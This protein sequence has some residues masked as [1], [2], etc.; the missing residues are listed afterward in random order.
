MPATPR[1]TT[2]SPSG[3]ASRRASWCWCPAARRKSPAACARTRRWR[4][5]ARRWPSCGAIR[6]HTRE[7][8]SQLTN[9]LRCLYL[10]ASGYQVTVT[11]LVGW[12]H[13]L[14]N[15][16][17]LARRTGQRKA[18]RRRAPARAARRVRPAGARARFA[19]PR[20]ANW[21][22]I[23]ITIAFALSS[24]HGPPSPPDRSRLSAPHHPARQQPAGDLRWPT[25]TTRC[26]WP[27]WSENARKFGV[28][29]HAYVLMSNHFHLLAT[30]RDGDRAFRR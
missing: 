19:L 9:V 27:C 14:K 25:P 28:A 17:I 3:C 23:P 11:E 2:R 24:R 7:M 20:A 16:L 8:G 21:G 10:E 30:P 6:L 26:C 4:C 18:Q 22:Q 13:S 5:R 15:E 1:P 12:E 29:I